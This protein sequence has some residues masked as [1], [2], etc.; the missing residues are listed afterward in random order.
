[1]REFRSWRK[2]LVFVFLSIITQVEC[3]TGVVLYLIWLL[4][5]ALV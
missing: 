5:I 2:Q 1:M 4:L 3:V